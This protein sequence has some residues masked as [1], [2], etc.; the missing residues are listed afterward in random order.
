MLPGIVHRIRS[1]TVIGSITAF[2]ALIV[3][4]LLWLR[5]PLY[6]GPFVVV[7]FLV[8]AIVGGVGIVIAWRLVRRGDRRLGAAIV[9]VNLLAVG[10][11]VSWALRLQPHA[12]GGGDPSPAFLAPPNTLWLPR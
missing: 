5:Y 11:G 4:Q 1:Y 10:L 2:G 12:F 7:A 6:F 9:L 3:D 8:P